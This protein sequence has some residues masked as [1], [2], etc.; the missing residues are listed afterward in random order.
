MKIRC[1]VTGRDARG[2]SV[3]ARDEDVE[4]VA[5]GSMP[6]YEFHRLW[7][8]E[9]LGQSL[10]SMMTFSALVSAACPKVSS[11]I[12]YLVEFGSGV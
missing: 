7:A 4:P 8:S 6:G 10:A 1:V 5:L 3:V 2:K 9:R 11:G 12:D